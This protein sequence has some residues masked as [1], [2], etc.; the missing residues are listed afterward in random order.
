[1]S[2]FQKIAEAYERRNKAKS[3]RLTP[4][5]ATPE[6]TSVLNLPTPMEEKSRR[7][8]EEFAD[9]VRG[10]SVAV[11]GRGGIHDIE[12]GEFIDSHDVVVRVHNMV[13]H[14]GDGPPPKGAPSSYPQ[15]PGDYGKV[16]NDWHHRI[17][18]RCDVWYMR[19]RLL[20]D[21]PH[22]EIVKEARRLASEFYGNG[23]RFVCV[24]HYHMHEDAD[25]T[26]WR[27]EF[28]IRYVTWEHYVNV[29]SMIGG[30]RANHGVIIVADLL[31]HEIKRL[32]VTGM[33]FWFNKDG[34]MESGVDECSHPT[35][36]AYDNLAFFA[37]LAEKRSDRFSIDDNMKKVWSVVKGK[38]WGFKWLFKDRQYS[39][40]LENMEQAGT[41]AMVLNLE[42]SVD[43]RRYMG[44]NLVQWGLKKEDIIFHTAPYC[45]DYE[46]PRAVKEAAKNDGFDFFVD[47]YEDHPPDDRKSIAVCWGICSVLRVIAECGIPRWSILDDMRV[48]GSHTGLMEVWRRRFA[49]RGDEFKVLQLSRVVTRDIPTLPNDY[50]DSVIVTGVSTD[51]DY[52]LLVSPHGAEWLLDEIAK[53]PF[54]GFATLFRD[55]IGLDIEGLYSTSL[56]FVVETAKSE[57]SQTPND[58]G[59]I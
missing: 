7:L 48:L 44:D 2:Q 23:G 3:E 19:R 46:S 41:K 33:P 21:V 18:K 31:R 52:G 59:I 14:L 11:V 43:R 57:L 55:M 49:D 38:P 28:E 29:M 37:K 12:Q 34:I 13:P 39:R 35:W 25:E 58:R 42:V 36:S 22:G 4:H 40:R 50:D 45:K 27:D 56:P 5:R 6:I 30:S 53:T 26:V 47:N 24:E 16:P 32:Y 51:S 17:G 1:M 20:G 15:P 8:D 9:F 10:K 54:K